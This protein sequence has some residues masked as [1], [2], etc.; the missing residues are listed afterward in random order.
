M[1][2]TYPSNGAFTFLL[3]LAKVSVI[4]PSS[5]PFLTP[6]PFLIDGINIPALGSPNPSSRIQIGRLNLFRFSFLGKHFICD[7]NLMNSLNSKSDSFFVEAHTLTQLHKTIVGIPILKVAFLKEPAMS[8]DAKQN[9]A[10]NFSASSL[11]ISS[12][13]VYRICG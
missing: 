10:L 9:G 8:R 11:P 5:C 4:T 3:F 1:Q 13:G 12:S 2:N 7:K 6:A